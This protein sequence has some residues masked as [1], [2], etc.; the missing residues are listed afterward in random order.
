M[1]LQAFSVNILTSVIR[2]PLW[3]RLTYYAERE[4][5]THN[6]NLFALRG[7]ALGGSRENSEAN[8]RDR[9]NKH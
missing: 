9:N 4:S 1:I 5:L 8:V 3:D 7:Y 2:T 6:R